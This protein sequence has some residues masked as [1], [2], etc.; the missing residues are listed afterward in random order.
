MLY[1]V[2][3][4]LPVS[5]IWSICGP[6]LVMTPA[7]RVAIFL[8]N[9]CAPVLV[10]FK[11]YKRSLGRVRSRSSKDGLDLEGEE[12]VYKSRFR[13]APHSAVKL[14]GVE[15]EDLSLE[16]RKRIIGYVRNRHSGAST[17]GGDDGGGS[18]AVYVVLSVLRGCAMLC[19]TP[20]VIGGKGQASID[21]DDKTIT[22]TEQE[23]L[24][25]LPSLKVAITGVRPMANTPALTLLAPP[26]PCI[27]LPAAPYTPLALT[28]TV[29]GTLEGI[30][31]AVASYAPAA[32]YNAQ[33]TAL[34][35]VDGSTQWSV[36][37]PCADDPTHYTAVCVFSVLL[38]IF[39][40]S[41]PTAHSL[42]VVLQDTDVLAAIRGTAP[43]HLTLVSAALLS[44][45]E[46][47]VLSPAVR[48][49]MLTDLAA[50]TQMIYASTTASAERH[51]LHEAALHLYEYATRLGLASF[52]AVTNA[53]MHATRPDHAH[54]APALVRMVMTLTGSSKPMDM[55]FVGLILVGVAVCGLTAK[56][57]AKS[58]LPLFTPIH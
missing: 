16:D 4:C 22:L 40:S 12:A 35:V 41:A 36:P 55:R 17:A 56:L 11:V 23:I 39:A 31:R 21:D 29:R 8:V 57:L 15:P 10:N 46:R 13:R 32:F 2:S 51:A 18:R 28:L 1:V 34:P 24:S 47:C 49:D 38:P 52:V 44:D 54:T 6:Q 26:S 33:P 27:P 58:L 14:S 9:F 3:T 20:F 53:L 48:H 42:C 37:A 25:L 7:W 50:L 5:L 45:L 19:V 30:Q 43:L